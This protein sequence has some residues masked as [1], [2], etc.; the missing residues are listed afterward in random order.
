MIVYVIAILLKALML[1]LNNPEVSNVIQCNYNAE[2]VDFG[3]MVFGT[4]Q[5]PLKLW[6]GDIRPN[7]IEDT[8]L[9]VTIPDTIRVVK[10]ETFIITVRLNELPENDEIAGFS[11]V[12]WHNSEVLD[13]QRE[14]ILRGDIVT[15]LFENNVTSD[16]RVNIVAASAT[17]YDRHGDLFYITGSAKKSGVFNE[18]FTINRFVLG[19][20]G[21]T[22]NLNLPRSIVVIS[23]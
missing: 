7:K 3:Q 8:A 17:G 20:S 18:V 10:G 14:F 1:Q 19:I 22:T 11:F 9:S 21:Y 12:A 15:G 4:K 23:E 6:N 2:N 13:I 5:V 16:G